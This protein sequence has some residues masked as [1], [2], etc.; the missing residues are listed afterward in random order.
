MARASVLCRMVG[1]LF[2]GGVLYPTTGWAVEDP[3][4]V[5]VPDASF[6]EWQGAGFS[7][8]NLYR[9]DPSLIATEGNTQD[10]LAVPTAAQFCAEPNNFIS[11]AVLSGVASRDSFGR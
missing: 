6:I 2:L 5:T 9:G 10:P 3:V 11:L 8:F 1:L 7:S 4:L